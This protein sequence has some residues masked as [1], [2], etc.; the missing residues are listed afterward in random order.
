MSSK[1]LSEAEENLVAAELKFK[2]E[3]PLKRKRIPTNRFRNEESSGSDNENAAELLSNDKKSKIKQ[4]KSTE[5]VKSANQAQCFSSILEAYR[6]VNDVKAEEPIIEVREEN[7]GEGL[8]DALSQASRVLI[9]LNDSLVYLDLDSQ[10]DAPQVSNYDSFSHAELVEEIH[11]L[12]MKITH[13]ESQHAQQCT[14]C[15]TQKPPPSIQQYLRQLLDEGAAGPSTIEVPVRETS[16]LNRVP[17][18]DGCDILVTK[19]Q[20]VNIIV[21]GRR[22]PKIMVSTFLRTFYTEEELSKMSY[23]GTKENLGLPVQFKECL[24]GMYMM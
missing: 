4:M 22:N 8:S 17:L 11:R 20:K 23:N 5:A 9:S 24:N 18:I 13:L 7:P 1:E 2:N 16:N 10:N 6:A 3:V 19:V 15:I 12:Q 21:E 14:K